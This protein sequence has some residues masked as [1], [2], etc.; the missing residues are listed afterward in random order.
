MELL[1]HGSVTSPA[2]FSAG[3]ATCGLKQSGRPDLMLLHSEHD[4]TAAGM[5]TRNQVVGATVTL[6]RETLAANSDRVRAIATNSGIANVCT[7]AT[8]LQ[9]ARRMQSLAAAAI[10][11][12][13]E[14][15]LV[16]STGVIGVQ[17]P[18]DKIR[19][20]LR[21]AAADQHPDR[22]MAAARA[23]MTTDTRPKH[24]AARIELPAGSVTIGAIVKGSG[25][26]HPNM[27][28][29]LAILTTDALIPART[30]RALL[31]SAVDQSFNRISVDGDTSTS[32]AVLL[33]A[34]G[35]TGLSCARGEAREAFAAA[36]THLATE[37]AHLVVRDGEGV[38]KFV[39][40][41]VSGARTKADAHRVANTIATS[42]LVK[43]AFA[44]SDPNWGRIM[45]AAGRA[46]VHFSLQRAALWIGAGA[47]EPLQLVQHGAPCDY[48]ETEA[49]QIFARSD[50][51]V[52]LD[53]GCGRAET[54]VWTGD[55]THEYVSINADYRT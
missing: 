47:G 9:N 41:R 25:M 19:A 35:A 7:G 39:S 50:F 5:F 20:G 43:T 8:G 42:P 54:T 28:T 37:L 53:L 21:T 51:N 15:V 22:G 3:V 17:L 27:A 48:Q 2:G 13:T 33:L 6:N 14:Q 49:A 23:I 16:L 46:G 36:I 29:L 30:L 10:R 52:Y 55:L 45:A 31:K 38:T 24:L 40:I 26:I 11:C 34:N 18:M 32:D 44:G 12:R 1:E 4:C